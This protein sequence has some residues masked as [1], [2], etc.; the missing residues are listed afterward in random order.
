MPL[1]K[2]CL[3]IIPALN[4][5]Q[6]I[7]SYVDEII[8]EGF[9]DVVIVNDGSDAKYGPIFEELTKM[10]NVTV[11]THSVNKGK[12]VAL[13][14]GL[15]YF[16]MHYNEHDWHGVITV[17]ADGQHLVK[18]LIKVYGEL[19][20]TKR[21]LVLGTRDFDESHVPK[22]SKFGNKMTTSIFR[23]FYGKIINDT[24]T[25]L[26]GISHD[27]VNDFLTAEGNRFEYEI[28]MLI[29]AVKD[30]VF[31]REVPIETV[32]INENESSHFRPFIDSFLIY[33]HLLKHFLLF[34]GV[35]ITSSAID[36]SIF[37]LLITLFGFIISSSMRISIAAVIARL[38]SSLYN[39]FM[40]KHFVFNNKQKISKS[41]FRYYLL[42]VTELVVSTILVIIVYRLTFFSEVIS[43]ILV[44]SVIFFFSF[45][46]QRYLVFRKIK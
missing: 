42:M 24:Q 4:P 5:K 33:R 28:N 17:D 19:E 14:Y 40:N 45:F 39:Y 15:E 29:K 22:K 6:N 18:D 41:I 35:A 9:T 44:D 43:K 11:L 23:L 13:K 21:W 26:R 27:L 34:I 32:Y 36:F 10:E 25:G 12:G 8:H 7:L 16:L 20:N 38:C 3:V 31:I 2:D 30:G 1:I 46:I 37:Q